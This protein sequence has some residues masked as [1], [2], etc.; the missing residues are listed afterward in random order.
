[1]SSEICLLSFF[2][3]CFG[4][5]TIFNLYSMLSFSL[6]LSVSC[7]FRDPV[8]LFTIRFLSA[9][10]NKSFCSQLCIF[11]ALVDV[12]F[13]FIHNMLCTGLFFF[14]FFYKKHFFFCLL[15][16]PFYLH[17]LVT[18]WVLWVYFV[19]LSMSVSPLC[20]CHKRPSI[21]TK[22]TRADVV[23]KWMLACT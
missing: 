12:M 6:C 5:C 10:V 2:F 17:E 16:L 20:V 3:N 8:K 19:C 23:L 11:C 18:C 4:H 14:C 9:Y 21:H 1:L 13:L 22:C 7:E 15:W